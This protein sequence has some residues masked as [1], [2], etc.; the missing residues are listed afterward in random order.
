MFLWPSPTDSE[1]V[2]DFSFCVGSRNTLVRLN[3]IPS[4]LTLLERFSSDAVLTGTAREFLYFLL[5][6][7]PQSLVMFFRMQHGLSQMHRI[8]RNPCLSLFHSFLGLLLWIA[9]EQPELQAA[10][11]EPDGLGMLDVS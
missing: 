6:E 8:V 1:T 5:F 7:Y 3:S 11:S 9:I 2:D 10:L 4:L